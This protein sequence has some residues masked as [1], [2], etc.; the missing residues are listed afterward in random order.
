MYA[1][2][3]AIFLGIVTALV[4]WMLKDYIYIVCNLIVYNIIGGVIKS[5]KNIKVI[6]TKEIVIP[7]H[8]I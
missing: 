8:A 5:I 6:D 2:Y 3:L 1:I 4:R 7:L